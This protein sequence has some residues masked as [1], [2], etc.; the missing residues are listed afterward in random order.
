MQLD[1]DGEAIPLQA[2]DQVRLPLPV[3]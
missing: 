3:G 2:F 1:A